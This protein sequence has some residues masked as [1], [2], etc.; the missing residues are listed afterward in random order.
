MMLLG[1]ELITVDTESV[2]SIIHIGQDELVAQVPFYNHQFRITVLSHP[3]TYINKVLIGS[4]QGKLQ[5]FNIRKQKCIFQYDGW[6]SG[7]TCIEQSPVIDVVAIG[8][9]NGQIHLHNL[10]TNQTLLSFRQ[11]W[12]KVMAI[13]FRTDGP[14]VMVSTSEIGHM[15]VWD[16]ENRRLLTQMRNIH[17]GAI[18]GCSFVFQH[19]LLITS[20]NDNS[21]KMW[22]F[23]QSDGKGDLLRKLQGHT[24]SP[25]KIEFYSPTSH[26][27]V[28]AAG[29]SS[30]RLFS[31]FTE[32]ANKSLGVASLNRKLSKHANSGNDPFRMDPII[33]FDFKLAR[34]KDFDNL[35]AIHRDSSTLTTWR[36]DHCR[37]GDHKLNHK[38]Q[39]RHPDLKATSVLVSNCGNFTVAG[40]GNGDILKFNIQSGMYRGTFKQKKSTPIAASPVTGLNCDQLCTILI[41]AQ[42]NELLFWNFKSTS[43]IDKLTM[44]HEIIRTR[45]N[46]QQNLI[47]ITFADHSLSI[48]DIETRTIIREFDRQTSRVNDVTF[49]SDSRWLICALA[50]RSLLVYDLVSTERVDHCLLPAACTSLTMSHTGE[51][52]ATA[53]EGHKGIFVWANMTLYIPTLIRPLPKDHQPRL[54]D[55]PV[56]RPEER[57]DRDDTEEKETD[58]ANELNEDVQMQEDD[59]PAEDPM[60]KSPEQIGRHL[61]TLS[62]VPASRWKNLI[63]LD[64]IKKRNR[65]KQAPTKPESAPF[66]LPVVAGVKPTLD[67]NKSN[68][69]NDGETDDTKIRNRLLLFSDF[70]QSLFDAGLGGDYNVVLDKLK[71]LGPAAI[72]VEIRSLDALPPLSAASDLNEPILIQFFLE[73]ILQRLRTNQDFELCNAY[74]SVLLK[75]HSDVIIRHA[76]YVKL[77]TQISAQLDQSWDRVRNTFS[78]T[79]CVLNY[80]RN[81]VI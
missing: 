15:A 33:D 23:D 29:D 31:I 1:D 9:K 34:E 32:R 43:L 27:I 72:D 79:L 76:K 75:C 11:D 10:K 17:E 78:Q 30:L 28:S 26:Y 16:I 49:S 4:E 5:L 80:I 69:R 24:L 45:S 18:T 22:R 20:S 48:V 67:A 50:D 47:A 3:S 25:T 63:H 12:G 14:P 58:Y 70:G 37:M 35:V 74:L 41:S 77:C 42:Q 39:L 73:A 71:V 44:K 64:L 66:F 38:R 54:L 7:V 40:Y 59:D 52:L 36:V 65:P 56:G 19:P 62:S 8:L 2:L 68:D 60:Y 81:S 6:N 61:V 51:F 46:S 55:L 21:L 13:S 57:V 53:H